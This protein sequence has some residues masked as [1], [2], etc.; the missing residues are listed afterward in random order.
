MKAKPAWIIA[1][2]AAPRSV[3]DDG[4]HGTFN[5]PPPEEHLGGWIT[6]GA[7]DRSIVLDGAWTAPMLR[8]LAAMMEA[9]DGG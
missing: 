8:D 7:G 4:L 6:Y 5:G 9:N 3:E 1:D 2:P